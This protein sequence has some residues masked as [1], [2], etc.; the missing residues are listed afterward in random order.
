MLSVLA[1]TVK[2]NK[3]P[4]SI[5]DILPS[6]AKFDLSREKIQAVLLSLV[7]QEI[8]RHTGNRYDFVV[9]LYKQWIAR[10]K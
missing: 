1:K 5:E 4:K 7:K 9:P 10:W 8:I 3:H 2:E 6:L